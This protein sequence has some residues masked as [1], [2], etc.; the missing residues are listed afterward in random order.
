MALKF[1]QDLVAWR[2]WQQSRH[3]LRRFRSALTAPSEQVFN[4]YA[5]GSSPQLMVAI[6]ATTPTA[7]SAF[8]API[9]RLESQHV[10]IVASV[11]L[12]GFLPPTW[13]SVASGVSREKT[14]EHLNDCVSIAG[15]YSGGH[16]LAA[17]N[18]A[19]SFSSSRDL[20]NVV[21]QHGLL[22]P[23]AP[24]LPLGSHLLAFSEAD[25]LFW[26]SGRH[27][28]TS[29][30]VG[31]QLLWEA[32]QHPVTSLESEVPQFLGQL[33]GAELPRSVTAGTAEQFCLATGAS[34][35]P[36]PSEKDI[37][38]RMQHRRW[39]RKG[40]HVERSSEALA[41][42]SRPVVSIFSTG[43][44][45][46]AAAGI[47]SWVTLS[48]PVPW[49]SEFWERYNMSPWGADPTPTPDIPKLEPARAISNS[50]QNMMGGN[51]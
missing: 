43:V 31:S 51:S 12:S 44:L 3:R 20:P 1:P 15:C 36:H 4:I 23:F 9:L 2:K 46:A 49:V 34:Y 40:I 22:T 5:S 47:P 42:S 21:S 29:E 41:D 13:T 10:I 11:N 50:L 38:S 32:Q 39:E 30:V 25:A 8:I 14:M 24:P 45:E 7:L 6:D 37:L 19:H 35:R 17:G 18:L 33:H 16:Y 26:K 27:D 48:Q 28:V